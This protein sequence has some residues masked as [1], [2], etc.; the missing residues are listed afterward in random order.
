M[1]ETISL[2]AD[3]GN[4]LSAYTAGAAAAPGVVILQ[5]IFGVNRHMR[6]VCD[7]FAV[8]G[9]R[10]IAPA[11]FDR[12][13]PGIELD[14]TPESVETG[15]GH[16]R[17]LGLD[18]P[19]ADI[20]AALAWLGDGPGG[21]CGYCW[22]GTLAWASATR[23]D[24]VAA[25]VCFYGG[26]IPGMARETPRCPVQFHFGETDH[27]ISMEAVETV[28]AAQP[29]AELYV[30]PAGH[31]FACEERASYHAESDE[32]GHE[33]AFAFLKRHLGG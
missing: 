17:G 10:A 2:T 7:N 6:H 19:L 20:R 26:G 28:R 25:A 18:G 9:F 5:E 31:G 13:E 8:N 29:D 33:R 24:G 4:T 15:R 23:L 30:Y 32:L 16:M 11:L 21:V 22:G 14:Y 3:D 1:G 27:S 12:I